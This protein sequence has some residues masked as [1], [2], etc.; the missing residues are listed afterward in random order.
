MLA[1]FNK[2]ANFEQYTIL[3]N[4]DGRWSESRRAIA[5]GLAEAMFAKFQ[6]T[7][8]I[9][10]NK[11]IGFMTNFKGNQIVFKTKTIEQSERGRSNKGQRCDRGEGKASIIRRIN[12]LLGDKAGKEKYA[13]GDTAKKYHCFHLWAKNCPTTVYRRRQNCKDENKYPSTLCGK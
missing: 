5:G 11:I 9:S 13:M 2:P 4:N 12:A 10:I 3:T 6:I 1:Q 8:L 7:D